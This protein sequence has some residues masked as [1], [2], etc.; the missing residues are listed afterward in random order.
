MKKIKVGINGFGRIGRAIFRINYLKKYFDIVVINDINPDN[1]NL[2]YLLKYDT[3]Y[4]QFPG[5]VTDNAQSM[6]IDGKK[7]RIYHQQ[8]IADL[9][10]EKHGVDVVIESSGV[11]KNL[12]YMKELKKRIKNV[13]AT[14]SPG[15]VDQTTIFGCNEKELNPKK[16]FLISASICDTIALSPI[17]KTI[18]KLAKIKHGYLTTLHPWLSYQNLLDGPSASWSQPGDVF[19]HYALGRSSIM[20]LIP[21]STSAVVAAEEIYPNLTDRIHSFSFRVPTAIVSGAVLIVHLSKKIDKEKLIETFK[22]VEKTQ[23]YDVIKNSTEPLTSVDYTGEG[24]SAVIDH[25]WTDVN[26]NLLKL[27]YW[28]DNEWGYSSRVVDL[29]REIGK[30]YS[31]R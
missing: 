7:I 11:K 28:Y 27:T 2:S 12:S 21:K 24:Y 29:I 15:N 18:E 1:H 31:K 23:K 16:N 4:G 17:I 13:V 5:K 19:S 30:K 10:W 8:S 22:K 20:N 26:R 9:P 14:Y 3:T 6:K 25:R